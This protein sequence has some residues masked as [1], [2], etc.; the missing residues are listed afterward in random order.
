MRYLLQH[1]GHAVESRGTAADALALKAQ[2]IKAATIAAKSTK[3]PVTAYY[4]RVIDTQT[5][6][7][8]KD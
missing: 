5:N 1:D 3:V 7:E 6:E 8:V 4:W 2:C